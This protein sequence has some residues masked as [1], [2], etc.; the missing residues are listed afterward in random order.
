MRTYKGHVNEKNFVGLSLTSHFIACGEFPP[1][2]RKDTTFHCVQLCFVTFLPP[3]Y[4]GS[5]NNSFYVYCK[6]VSNHMLKYTF[7][8]GRSMLVSHAKDATYRTYQ[9]VTKHFMCS[10]TRA[11]L[12]LK[13][14]KIQPNLSALFGG[15]KCVTFLTTLCC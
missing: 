2:S 7:N 3:H 14:K 6:H 8:V 9:D 13:L 12:P 1:P 15:G 10:Q 5:E 11:L 4:T